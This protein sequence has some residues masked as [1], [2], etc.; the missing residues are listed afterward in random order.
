[1]IASETHDSSQANESPGDDDVIAAGLQR[2]IE[3][4]HQ[5][6]QA[7]IHLGGV[8]ALIQ[9]ERQNPRTPGEEIGETAD[10]ELHQ[11]VIFVVERAEKEDVHA[12]RP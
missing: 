2:A 1:M 10:G 8:L 5:A 4:R 3:E 11:S 7:P 12:A 9:A 6:A